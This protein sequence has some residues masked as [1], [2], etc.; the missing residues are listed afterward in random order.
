MMNGESNFDD[1]GNFHE[2]FGLDNVT[3]GNAGPREVSK[4]LLEFRMRFL[5]EELE[6][7]VEAVGYKLVGDS[8]GNI[9][10][11]EV[12]SEFPDHAQAFD[13]LLDLTYVAMGTAHLEGY[14]WQQGWDRVQRANITKER[15]K[16]D[17]SNSARNSSFD[18][19]KP[20]G[21]TA[22]DI[23]GLLR[24]LGWQDQEINL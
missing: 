12:N 22:P 13:A 20:A 8:W 6:E 5:I 15:A 14:P 23:A 9:S 1:V 3:Y 16:P 24:E 21:W 18:V 11:Q 17:G 2:K 4:K 19:V 10:I 7:F